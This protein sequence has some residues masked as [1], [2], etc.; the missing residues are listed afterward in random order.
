MSI[1]ALLGWTAAGAAYLMYRSERKERIETTRSLRDRLHRSQWA[2]LKLENI[3][4][5][6]QMIDV[7]QAKK[8][9]RK[10]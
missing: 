4:A 5:W 8:S 6:R 2:N 10:N 7:R 3:L 1:L 9:N